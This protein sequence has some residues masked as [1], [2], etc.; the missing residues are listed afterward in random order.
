MDEIA[1]LLGQPKDV[2]VLHGAGKGEE[3][4]PTEKK[5]TDVATSS[6]KNEE[7]SPSKKKGADVAANLGEA[8]N[9]P[10]DLPRQWIKCNRQKGTRSKAAATPPPQWRERWSRSSPSRS[11]SPER[12]E[13]IGARPL[14]RR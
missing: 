1:W 4:S 5:A 3:A 11:R 10:D 2:V 13:P 12:P 14:P 8:E 9:D 6:G 7:A